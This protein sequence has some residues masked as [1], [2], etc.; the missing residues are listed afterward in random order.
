[1][2]PWSDLFPQKTSGLNFSH[3]RRCPRTSCDDSVFATVPSFIL[4]FYDSAALLVSDSR[5]CASPLDLAGD[6]CHSIFI[7]VPLGDS[8][9]DLEM[10]L[11]QFAIDTAMIDQKNSRNEL[12]KAPRCLEQAPNKFCFLCLAEFIF[13]PRLVKSQTEALPVV[14][15]LI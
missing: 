10:C 12:S 3:E 7:L 4:V 2:P 1:M 6:K 15:A 9:C 13:E 5:R 8:D 11:M 14:I